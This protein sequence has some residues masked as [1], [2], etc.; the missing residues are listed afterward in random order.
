MGL[1]SRPVMIASLI[2][3]SVGVPYLASQN[4]AG[5][6]SPGSVAVAPQHAGPTGTAATPVLGTQP[7]TAPP[8][9]SPIGAMPSFN[10]PVSPTAAASMAVA[11][12]AGTP[13][14]AAP[15]QRLDGAQFTTVAQVLRFD[16][17]KDWVY[18]NWSRK[19]TAPTDV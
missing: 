3:A 2:G 11:G 16:V 5:P 19:T 15:A 14:A 6:A 17:T 10:T 13:A 12:T 18:R 1:A 9:A 4:N 7:L 8:L